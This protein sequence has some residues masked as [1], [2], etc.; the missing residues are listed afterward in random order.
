V[1][2]DAFL[3]EVERRTFRWFWDLADPKTGL[4]PDRWPTK[5]FSSVA[6][7]GFGLTAYGIGAERGF[8]TRGEAARRALAVMK[9]LHD[10]PQGPEPDGKTGYRGF[11]YHFL[12]MGSGARFK[13][14][15]LS[16]IDTTLMVAGALFCAEYFDRDDPV[17]AE[18]RSTADKLYRRIEWDW[19]RPRAPLVSMGWYPEQGFHKMDWKGYDEAML[20]YLLALGSPTHPVEPQAWKAYTASYDWKPFYG[21]EYLMFGPLYGYQYSH[22]YVDFRGIRDEFMRGRKLDYFENSRR[23]VLSHRAYAIANPE[24]FKGYGKDFWGL[25]AC[26]GPID[27]SIEYRGR[28]VLFHTYS[29]RAPG[30]IWKTDDGTLAPTGAGASIPFAPELAIAS[31]RAM[32]REWG[33]DLYTEYGFLDS[34]N[35]SFDFKDAKLFMGRLVPGKGWVAGD[36]LGIDQGPLIAMIENHRS[37]LVWR[38]MAKNPYLAAGLRRAGFTGG[39][40]ERPAKGSKSP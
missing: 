30:P 9:F 20:L 38:K 11:L 14:V 13:T 36:Y 22:V 28:P 2:D 1:S 10:A 5:S 27:A 23:A 21:Q 24:G 25:T 31:L 37:G 6:A 17:E 12:D 34:F 32:E 15:E 16:T 39:W 33:K 4:V 8:V 26:D 18:I 19:A 29:G 7:V 35:A 3:D 40:L